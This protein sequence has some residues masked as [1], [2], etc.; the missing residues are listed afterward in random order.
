M[1]LP[2]LCSGWAE[3]LYGTQRF[4]VKSN[5]S[6]H[7]EA[8]AVVRGIRRPGH[9]LLA[10]TEVKGGPLQWQIVSSGRALGAGTGRPPGHPV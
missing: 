2:L 6:I 5:P 7:C 3:R 8:H 4:P 10:H 1:C 9:S